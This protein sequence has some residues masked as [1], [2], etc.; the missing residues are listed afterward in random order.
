MKK[1][2]YPSISILTITYNPDHRIFTR[3]LESIKKQQYPKHKIDHI[4]V[5]GGS[6]KNIIS[7]AEKYGCTVIIRKDLRDQSEARRSYAVKKAKHE[8]LLWLESDNILREPNALKELVQPFIDDP[9][10][11]STFSLHYAHNRKAYLLDRYCA[12]IGASDPVAFYLKKTDREPWFVNQY[13]KGKIIKR[14]QT[15][16]VVEFTKDT[17]PTVGDNGFLTR[18]SILRKANISPEDYVHIDIYVDL[19]KLGYNRFAVVRSVSIEHIIGDNLLNLIRRRMLYAHRYSL[20]SYMQNRRYLV[21]NMDSLK[22]RINLVWYVIASGTII[23]PL[24]TAV[25]GYLVLRDKAWFLHPIA[26]L[27]FLLYYMKHTASSLPAMRL[28]K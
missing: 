15:Y 22:D 4:V 5:D 18:R 26:C 1:E 9:K 23:H 19:M 8:I 14:K 21:F 20:S 3:S 2:K 28:A 7:L 17:L 24:I 12:L 13:T 11:I 25:R 6:N 16:D 27:L 10:V